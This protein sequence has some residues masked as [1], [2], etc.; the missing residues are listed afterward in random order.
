[1]SFLFGN[2]VR[3]D[4]QSAETE[5]PPLHADLP[6]A[7][8]KR[9]YADLI[10]RRPALLDQKLKLH[11]RI[12]DEFNLA[13]LDKLSPEELRRQVQTYIDGYI[14]AEHL[15]LNQKETEVF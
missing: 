13:L 7:D 14:R 4:R 15:S 12:V 11:A 5:A 6:Q 3:A 8:F 1:M 2:T 9:F 10:A